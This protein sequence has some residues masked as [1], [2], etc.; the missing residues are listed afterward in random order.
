MISFIAGDLFAEKKI[1][2]QLLDRVRKDSLNQFT[3]LLSGRGGLQACGDTELIGVA[4]SEITII[5]YL[6]QP[7]W[8]TSYSALS[9]RLKKTAS[10]PA[11][12]PSKC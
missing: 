3:V 12:S 5:Y 7:G 4:L 9:A 8:L 1:V 11:A 10:I 2:P 6:H